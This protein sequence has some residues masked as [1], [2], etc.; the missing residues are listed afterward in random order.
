M[1]D[2]Y[3]LSRPLVLAFA[4]LFRWSHEGCTYALA[5]GLCAV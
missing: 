5:L 1:V 3:L 4:G 2:C